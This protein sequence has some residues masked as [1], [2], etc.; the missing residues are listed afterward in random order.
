MMTDSGTFFT[1]NIIFF[2][3]LLSHFVPFSSYFLILWNNILEMLVLTTV[4]SGT[5]WSWRF[6]GI[7]F[8][9]V[10]DFLQNQIKRKKKR[11]ERKFD[12]FSQDLSVTVSIER[13]C[14]LSRPGFRVRGKKERPNHRDLDDGTVSLM[15]M[16]MMMMMKRGPKKDS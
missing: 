10:L 8:L 12:I 13:R 3:S 11:S 7:F 9:L 5:F 2:F 15:K 16:M 1:P 14:M 6:S 4:Q